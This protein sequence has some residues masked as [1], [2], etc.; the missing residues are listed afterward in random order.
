[1]QL[2][3][4]YEVRSRYL[5]KV[6]PT[7]TDEEIK[8]F[9]T[10]AYGYGYCS[11]LSRKKVIKIINKILAGNSEPKILDSDILEAQLALYS[12]KSINADKKIIKKVVKTTFIFLF[13]KKIFAN[14]KQLLQR[15]IK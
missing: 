10:I 1:M 12:C 9:T 5:K 11:F 2:K 4:A 8:Q 14:T 15:K 13:G 6:C 7:I 3:K